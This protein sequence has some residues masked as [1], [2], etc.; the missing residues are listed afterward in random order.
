MGSIRIYKK[1]G[2]KFRISFFR[3]MPYNWDYYN[4]N[5]FNQGSD[6][7]ICLEMTAII[8]LKVGLEK[9]MGFPESEGMMSLKKRKNIISLEGIKR[10]IQ[11]I[12]NGKL[13]LNNEEAVEN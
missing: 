12:E 4:V 7:G 8:A 11:D 2:K 3:V 10:V 1:N 5:E 13:N 9:L 6:R